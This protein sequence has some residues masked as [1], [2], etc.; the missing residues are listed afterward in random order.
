MET[1]EFEAPNVAE[2]SSAHAIPAVG[3][4]NRGR[5]VD[6][7]HNLYAVLLAIVRHDLQQ[8]P[9]VTIGA[10][11]TL[12]KA[13]S[14]GAQ[15]AQLARA[16][17]AVN[18]L[19]DQLDQLVGSLRLFDRSSS[20]REEVV[21]LDPIFA[22]AQAE[23]TEPA[24]LRG[25]TLRIIRTRAAVSTNP[26][27]LR[28]ILQNLI[29]NAIDYTPYG[30]RVLVAARR[31][32]ATVRLEVRDN[33]IGI[34]A[35]E[36]ADIFKPF[37]RVDRTRADGLG[38]GLFI[39]K[40]AAAHLGHNIEVNSVRGHGSRFAVSINH[41]PVPIQRNPVGDTLNAGERG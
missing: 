35:N 27:L 9:Q 37:H 2:L 14:S 40:C 41:A 12:A 18:K 24:R 39:V 10:H 11:D 5:V 17:N 29:R 38:L 25:I 1:I 21:E 22:Q 15:Q 36:L 33:G 34:S 6:K 3:F 31:R 8:P 23:F 32:G 13:L 20:N 28:G 7:H 30:G 19:S 16:K 4:N 26:V